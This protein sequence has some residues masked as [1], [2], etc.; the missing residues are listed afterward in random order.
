MRKRSHD[1]GDGALLSGSV[2]AT[3]TP[4][5]LFFWAG[6]SQKPR[7]NR[8][9]P[10]DSLAHPLITGPHTLCLTFETCCPTISLISWHSEAA[11]VGVLDRICSDEH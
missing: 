11:D 6:A 9:R 5:A 8:P 2:F 1:L 7:P 10:S 4:D 3:R